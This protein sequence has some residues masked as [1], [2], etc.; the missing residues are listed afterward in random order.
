[1]AQLVASKCVCSARK[2]LWGAEQHFCV[3]P[4]SHLTPTSGFYVLTNQRLDFSIDLLWY[5]CV[6]ECVL[7]GGDVI[8]DVS[9]LESLGVV[10]S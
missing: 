4:K 2:L 9:S 6:S 10:W 1:M 8:F 7:A 3:S 5:V